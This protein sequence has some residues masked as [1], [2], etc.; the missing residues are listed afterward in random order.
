MVDVGGWSRTSVLLWQALPIDDSAEVGQKCESHVRRSIISD[1]VSML[2]VIG[3]YFLP[4]FNH[5]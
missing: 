3:A 2:Q 1:L 5:I 4:M